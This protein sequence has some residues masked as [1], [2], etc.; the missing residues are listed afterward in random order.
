MRFLL[1]VL[2]AYVVYRIIKGLL[3]PAKE[4]RKGPEGGVI[5]EM[6]QDPFCKIYVPRKEAVRRIIAGQEVLFCSNECAE[7][8]EAERN[9]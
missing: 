9:S 4:I 3:R 2:A 1:L 5:D 6:V 8:F 7:K